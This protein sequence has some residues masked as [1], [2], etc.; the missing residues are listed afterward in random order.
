MTPLR[1]LLAPVT[2]IWMFC[3]IGTVALVPVALWVTATDPHAAECTC[4]HGP[5]AA[6][7]MHQKPSGKSARCVMQAANGS[8]A[9]VL[10]TFV[11]MAG[12]VPEPTSSIQPAIPSAHH[13]GTDVQIVGERPV[14]PDPPPPRV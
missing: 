3:Q 5:G 6:C 8:G 11:G 1:R 13:D 14:P 10:T 2:A 9:A 12:L 7:P 4:G